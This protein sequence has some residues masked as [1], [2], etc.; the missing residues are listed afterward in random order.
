VQHLQ[1][2]I[3]R[4]VR[5]SAASRRGHTPPSSSPPCLWACRFFRAEGGGGEGGGADGAPPPKQRP[6]S[7]TGI[8]YEAFRASML[9]HG[10]RVEG[11]EDTA[12]ARRVQQTRLGE[13]TVFHVYQ[14]GKAYQ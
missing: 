6:Q 7:A 12:A 8:K 9:R 4:A 5:P 13:S 10:L 1:G 3:C 2:T 14:G 11:V